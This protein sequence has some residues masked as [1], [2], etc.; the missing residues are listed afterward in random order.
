MNCKLP[1]GTRRFALVL[2]A[3]MLL[4]SGCSADFSG[5]PEST[6]TTQALENETTTE[7]T[8]SDS[9]LS[10]RF[11][12]VTESLNGSNFTLIL[13]ER[14]DGENAT[15]LEREYRL[16]GGESVD[17]SS[18]IGPKATYHATIKF[19]NGN[20]STARISEREGIVLYVTEG[21]VVRR[22]KEVI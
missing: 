22:E 8:T 15:V 13:R 3:A 18:N 17:L 5:T 16:D 9:R 20:S 21:E 1:G 12:I 2:V 6:T 14:A 4:L 19:E 11:R 10:Y 7:P